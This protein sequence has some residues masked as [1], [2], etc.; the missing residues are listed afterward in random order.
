MVGMFRCAQ[1]DSLQILGR[2]KYGDG[3][4]VFPDDP[5]EILRRQPF[6]KTISPV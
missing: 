3:A 5:E 6:R 2:K 4:Y 1:D